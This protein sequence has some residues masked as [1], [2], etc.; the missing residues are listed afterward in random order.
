M[1][2]SIS[3]H[4]ARDAEAIVMRSYG[5]PAVLRLETVGLPPL[6]G[7]EIRIRSLASAV[8][9]S[10]LEI[11]AGRWPIRR[12]PPFPYIPGLEVVGEIVETGSAVADFRLGDRVI[13]MM[14]GLGGVRAA[15]SGGYARCVTVAES[16]AARVPDG[17]DPH[18]MAA[19]GLAGVTAFEGLRRLGAIAG[20][21]I[22]V[23]GA[24]G[25]VGSAAVSLARAQ[26]ADVIA[27]VSRIERADYVRSLGAGEI[28]LSHEVAAGQL[29]AGSIDGVLDTV[30]GD[31]FAPCVTA[32]RS[33]GTLSLVGAVGG[34]ALALDAYRLVDVTLTGYSSETLTGGDL[35]QAVASIGTWLRQGTVLASFHTLFPLRDAAAA[36]Q[37]LE[38]HGVE[39]RVLLVPEI[40]S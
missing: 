9:H 40:A 19:L 31:L 14:Q 5:P 2:R 11:R 20:R 33:G 38:R 35:R 23:T 7:D 17:V 18:A 27:I 12:D 6:A 15:R 21:R 4:A 30:A 1:P 26:E 32:L 13:T 34:S 25:G 36:H 8:N 10:D 28:L 39:G 22:A 3:D 37:L 16:A 29:G 24:A